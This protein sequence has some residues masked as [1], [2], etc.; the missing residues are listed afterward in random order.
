M[1][2]GAVLGTFFAMVV[3]QE[4]MIRSIALLCF[5]VAS[6]CVPAEDQASAAALQLQRLSEARHLWQATTPINQDYDFSY[7]RSCYCPLH[8]QVISIRVRGGE[9]TDFSLSKQSLSSANK[10]MFAPLVR[11]VPDLFDEVLSLIE[12]SLVEGTRL[13][14]TYDRDY[15][16]PSRIEWTS[17]EN[18]GH[19]GRFTL[20]I[21]GVQVGENGV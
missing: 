14:V 4:T 7:E 6:A 18:D 11:T 8:G 20:R 10:E 3:S 12:H 16:H 19:H 17:A 15:G 2:V 13:E 5:I 9:I 21:V 1:E